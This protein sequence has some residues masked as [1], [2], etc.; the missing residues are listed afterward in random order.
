M[1]IDTKIYSVTIYKD[2]ALV[3][4]ASSIKLDKG[5]HKIT[6]ENLP[7]SIN[8]NT[9]QVSSSEGLILY[10]VKIKKVFLKEIPDEKKKELVK[11]SEL[12][13]NQIAEITDKI[14]NTNKEKDFLQNLANKTADS[15]KKSM[16]SFIEVDKL[17]GMLD[18]YRERLNI[19]DTEIRNLNKE[20]FKL[21]ESLKKIKLQLTNFN[22]NQ[23]KTKNQVELKVLITKNT[24]INLGISYIVFG[25]SWKPSYDLRANTDTKKTSISYDAVIKQ[26]TGEKWSDVE[27][28]LSTA[29]P[30]ISAIKPKLSPWYL[31]FEDDFDDDI[32]EAE[33]EERKKFSKLKKKVALP[34]RSIKLDDEM[35]TMVMTPPKKPE[36]KIESGATSVVFA[37]PGTNSIIDNNQ[38]HKVGITNFNFDAKFQYVAVPK[39]TPFA[40]LNIK[41]KN[42]SDYPMLA[43]NANVFLDNNYVT[44]TKLNLVAPNE[45]FQNSLGIDEGI[46]I[47]HKLVNRL[48]KDEGIFSKKNKLT[49][50]YKI[51]VKN[52][53]KSTEKIQIQDQL[54]IS[55]HKDIKIELIKPKYKENTDEIKINE[56][57][58]IEWNLE[59]EA[60]KEI[61]IPLIFSIEYPR[62]EI[63]EGI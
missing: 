29:K 42:S 50:E 20:H 27:L 34:K 14:T 57:Q 31:S 9:L 13:V 28:K 44:N 5:E 21:E 52:K 8:E 33:F 26:N 60:G 23:L 51:I 19:L 25:A 53:K 22:Q 48:G 4:R 2:R 63:L 56:F 24:E 12:I 59:I 18:F 62:D 10:D 7:L 16:L 1:K 32:I 37:I 43:G 46:S 55:Q 38:E 6:I 47:E 3:N 49:Y 15:S 39:I 41:M 45:E 36:A 54:P 17:G 58:Y 11:E 35:M 61:I 40:Y 30:H